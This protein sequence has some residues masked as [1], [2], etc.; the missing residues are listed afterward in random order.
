MGWVFSTG[1]HLPARCRCDL[2]FTSG[3][4]AWHNEG[5]RSS[6]GLEMNK[7][8]WLLLTEEKHGNRYP[9]TKIAGA[10]KIEIKARQGDWVRVVICASLNK[11]P[12]RTMHFPRPLSNGQAVRRRGLDKASSCRLHSLVVGSQTAMRYLISSEKGNG[13]GKEKEKEKWKG[14]NI[15]QPQG[16]GTRNYHGAWT[17]PDIDRTSWSENI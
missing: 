15:R 10:R 14:K 3:A 1:D 17:Q 16:E 11:A 7:A 6:P 2:T 5:H 8:S 9:R 12:R 4:A 13:G